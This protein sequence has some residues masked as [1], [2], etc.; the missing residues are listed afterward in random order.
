LEK[1]M[2]WFWI[3]YFTVGICILAEPFV[4]AWDMTDDHWA[5]KVGGGILALLIWPVVFFINSDK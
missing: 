5:I 1:V 4:E 3:F 2:T